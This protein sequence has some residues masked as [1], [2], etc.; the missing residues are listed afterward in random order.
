MFHHACVILG[1]MGTLIDIGPELVRTRRALGMSQR[2]LG[3]RVGVKQPQIAR[4]EANAY[5]TASLERVDAVARTLGF[6]DGPALPMAA[7]ATAAYSAGTAVRP[8][9]DLGEVAARLREHSDE[10][11]E[12]GVLR[13]RAFGSFATGQQTDDSDV[14]LLVDFGPIVGFEFMHAGIR[15]EE[16]LGRSVDTVRESLVRARLRDRVTREAIEVWRA[17]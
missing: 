11:R 9:R 6:E 3:E 10:L 5:R 16:I 12:L 17:G 14:D 15:L 13:L 8:V 4:W 2:E 7:E 1:D